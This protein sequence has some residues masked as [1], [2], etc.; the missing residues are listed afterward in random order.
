M[1]RSTSASFPRAS[2]AQQ[3]ATEY[4]VAFQLKVAE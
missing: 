1:W 4:E 2:G 3:A